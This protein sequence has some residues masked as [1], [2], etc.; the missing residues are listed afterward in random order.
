[1]FNLIKYT[2]LPEL[3]EIFEIVISL[4]SQDSQGYF[5]L[6]RVGD[7]IK[8]LNLNV[9]HKEF[10]FAMNYFLHRKNLFVYAKR[11]KPKKGGR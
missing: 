11:K 10:W 3:W 4:S 7:Y 8:D 5:T 2:P 9:T 6:G 1:M